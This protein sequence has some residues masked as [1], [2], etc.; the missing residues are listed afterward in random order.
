V[1]ETP[2]SIPNPEVKPYSVDGTARVTLWESRTL[3]N[4]L[5]REGHFSLSAPFLFT[6]NPLGMEQGHGITTPA[7]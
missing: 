6:V 4:I 3:P 7:F 2:G 1:R 5:Y